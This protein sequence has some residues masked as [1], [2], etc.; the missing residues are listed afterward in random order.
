MRQTQVWDHQ[1]SCGMQAEGLS[2]QTLD[3]VQQVVH[4]P[5]LATLAAFLGAFSKVCFRLLLPAIGSA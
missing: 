3:Q 1:N 5:G 2:L 4:L